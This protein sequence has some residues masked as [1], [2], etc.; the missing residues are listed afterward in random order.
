MKLKIEFINGEE[1]IIEDIRAHDFKVMSTK[2]MQQILIL[3]SETESY[4]T[5]MIV[6]MEQVNEV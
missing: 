5:N 3:T 2:I 1:R 4:P 6:K